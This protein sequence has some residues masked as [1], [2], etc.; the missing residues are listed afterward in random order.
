MQ[1]ASKG[2]TNFWRLE[3]GYS[4]RRSKIVDD[5]LELH[6]DAI[7]DKVEGRRN[8]EEHSARNQAVLDRGRSLLTSQEFFIVMLSCRDHVA[9]Q[10]LL[11]SVISV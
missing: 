7:P 9:P 3:P 2:A 8:R 1:F 5:G 6:V 4:L 11:P 10:N